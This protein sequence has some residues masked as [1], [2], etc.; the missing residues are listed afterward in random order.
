MFNSDQCKGSS[1]GK[2]DRGRHGRNAPPN[3]PGILPS[4]KFN[5]LHQVSPRM[6]P[7]WCPGCYYQ[8]WKKSVCW[9]AAHIHPPMTGNAPDCA[10]AREICKS[11]FLD[12]SYHLMVCVQRLQ[13]CVS[14]SLLLFSIKHLGKMHKFKM[15]NNFWV[16][17]PQDFFMLVKIFRCQKVSKLLTVKK[18]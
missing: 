12:N 4:H 17:F 7:R 14:L 2:E 10:W 18:S 8:H 13:L 6:L 9:S 1:K 15:L 3:P 5:S 16:L 11:H